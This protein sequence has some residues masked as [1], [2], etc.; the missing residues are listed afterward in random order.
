MDRD[1]AIEQFEYLTNLLPLSVKLGFLFVNSC[2]SPCL[3][4]IIHL[5][6]ILERCPVQNVSDSDDSNN[7]KHTLVKLLWM[8][9]MWSSHLHYQSPIV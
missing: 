7:L 6:T 3:P 5:H 4:A 1:R 8:T 9:D 2:L